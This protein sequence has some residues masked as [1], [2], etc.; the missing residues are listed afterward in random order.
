[1]LNLNELLETG[2]SA[3][4]KKTVDIDDAAGHSS[5]YLGQYLSTSACAA[6]AVQAAMKATENLL[7]EGYLS[8]GWRIEIEHDAP[9]MM[10]TTVTVRATLREIRGNRLIFD[11]AASDALGAVFRAVN[12]RVVVNRLGLEDRAEKRAM[13]LKELKE[14]L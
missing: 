9:A 11:I 4:I 3:E 5:P 1:M 10:G 6:L 2:L 7:P 8:V 14:R 13:Q 12:E